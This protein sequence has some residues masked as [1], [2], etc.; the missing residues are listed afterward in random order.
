MSHSVLNNGLHDEGGHLDLAATGLHVLGQHDAV[1]AK[2]R[3]LDGEVAARLL[4]LGPQRDGRLGALER[5]AV[6]DRE[7]AQQ[8]AGPRGVGAGER[9]NGVERVEQEVRVDLRLQGLDLG[10]RGNLGLAVELVHRELRRQKLGKAAGNCQLGAV[11][12]SAVAVVELDGT[13]GAL[14]DRQ[15]HN[16]A[17][18]VGLDRL[19][20][21]AAQNALSAVPVA[22]VEVGEGLD[23]P[24]LNN[25][26]GWPAIG[27]ALYPAVRALAHVGKGVVHVGHG[28]GNGLGLG[29]KQ[30]AHGTAVLGVETAA[31]VVLRRRGHAQGALG[32]LRALVVGGQQQRAAER[33]GRGDSHARHDD[34]RQVGRNETPRQHAQKRNGHKA[35]AQVGRE[36]QVGDGAVDLHY[37]SPAMG[38]ASSRLPRFLGALRFSSSGGVPM[39]TSVLASALSSHSD[40]M[41]RGQ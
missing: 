4:E 34:R 12:R 36:R 37:S 23:A 10:A 40:A 9:R 16:N 14:R 7:L 15:R 38:R 11:D 25:L 21:K 22:L 41:M 33:H 20:E 28:D 26:R 35:Q 2:A 27:A 29:E 13:H 17:H 18:G 3:L 32:C 1:L 8:V 31:H 6:E 39:V 24:A 19:G 30:L 5:A